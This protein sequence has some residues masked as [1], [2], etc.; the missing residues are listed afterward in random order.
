M[1]TETWIIFGL[2]A[3]M[4]V[5]FLSDRIRLDLVALLALLV[6]VLTPILTPAEALASFGDPILLTIAG[7][8]V[9]G[10]G[11][12]QTG[13]ADAVGQRLRLIAGN[14][15]RRVIVVTMVLVALF[16]A[17]MSSTGTVAIFLPTRRGQP[18]SRYWFE[19]CTAS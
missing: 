14:T 3:V 4:V 7:L 11:L 13:V 18:G 10:A 17:V 9:V 2:L 1:N 8:F 6:L 16:S 19:S 12:L 15:E 5:L